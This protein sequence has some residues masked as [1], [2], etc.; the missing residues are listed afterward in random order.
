MANIDHEDLANLQTVIAIKTALQKDEGELFD[1]CV[2]YGE[3]QEGPD[4]SRMGWFINLQRLLTQYENRTGRE[5]TG[6]EQTRLTKWLKVEL[7]KRRHILGN[8]SVEV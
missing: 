6:D 3:I 2:Y 1:L 8:D 4:Y 5:L 7:P